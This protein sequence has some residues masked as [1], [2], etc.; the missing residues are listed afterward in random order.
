MHIEHRRPFSEF[1]HL[2][3]SHDP[4]VQLQAQG[5]GAWPSQV[6]QVLVEGRPLRAAGGAVMLAVQ[7]DSLGEHLPGVAIGNVS[8]AVAMAGEAGRNGTKLLSTQCRCCAANAAA[9]PLPRGPLGDR[10]HPIAGWVRSK[11]TLKVSAESRN[12]NEVAP[13]LRFSHYALNCYLQALSAV[14]FE[15]NATAVWHN[16]SKVKFSWTLITS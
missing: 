4:L 1:E 2:V 12:S 15:T 16:I 9:I 6:Q 3:A 8:G 14:Q 11:Q 7:P 10:L 13:I 5:R